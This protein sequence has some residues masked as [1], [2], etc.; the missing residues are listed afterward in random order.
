MGTKLRRIGMT[1]VIVMITCSRP[2][3]TLAQDMR[4][5]SAALA[6]KIAASGRKTVAVVD[7]TDLQGCVT[8]LGRYMAEDI[9][10]ALLDNA[11]GFEVI[12]R[13]S[14]RVLMQEHKLASTGIIDPAT[15]RQLG[16]IAGVDA[17]VTG[18]IAPLSDS[19]HVSA[20][21]LDTESAKMLGGI[22]AEIPRT[23]AVDE[24][25]SKGV[26]NCAPMT[27]SLQSPPIAGNQGEMAHPAMAGTNRSGQ[28]TLGDFSI[29]ILRCGFNG[30][31][32]NCYGTAVNQGSSPEQFAIDALKTYMID[33]LGD[34][35]TANSGSIGV[36]VKIG[37]NDRWD[38]MNQLFGQV[39]QPGLPV[40]FELHGLR[41]KDGAKT[42]SIVLV[43]GE[44]QTIIR[45]IVLHG[46]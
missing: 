1:A 46:Q 38:Y 34:Q 28:V 35:S 26:A 13:T 6:T 11:K 2:F 3:C 32:I 31:R 16:K 14:L 41:M 29:K 30:D 25:L 22:T 8:E 21:V 45:D 44:G 19:V 37:A 9:S 33:D 40:S 42:V 43:T 10:V 23:K 15:A 18:T 17:L 27:T 20:K 36:G 4:P 5:A 7:F 12:D 24:L 39:L